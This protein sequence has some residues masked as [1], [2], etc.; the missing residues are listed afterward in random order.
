MEMREVRNLQRKSLRSYRVKLSERSARNQDRPHIHIFVVNVKY[1]IWPFK[2][3]ARDSPK[4]QLIGRP[5]KKKKENR[6]GYWSKAHHPS[7]VDNGQG[8]ILIFSWIKLTR[9]HKGVS[10]ILNEEVN[11]YN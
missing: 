5:W 7:Y 4:V 3:Q 8:R 10:L 9:T 1:T 11:N 2:W 6:K